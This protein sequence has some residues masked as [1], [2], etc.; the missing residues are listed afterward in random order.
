MYSIR[1]TT[2]SNTQD[3]NGMRIAESK[4][5]DTKSFLKE[6]EALRVAGKKLV[7]TNGC[8]DVLHRGHITYLQFARQQGDALVVGINADASVKRA[9]GPTRP[10]YPEEDR[11]LVL[12]ALECV[13]YVIRFEED[14]PASLIAQIMPDILVKGADWAHYVSGREMVEAHGGKVV[15]ADIVPGKSTTNTLAKLKDA[16]NA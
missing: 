5:C 15:L 6:R 16:E 1:K 13:D 14:E 8:F 9:K 12:A 4:Q 3:I 10:I 11:A 2:C 7:F